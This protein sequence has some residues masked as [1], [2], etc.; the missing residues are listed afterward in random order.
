MSVDSW[1]F[2]SNSSTS[3]NGSSAIWSASA[4]LVDGS[5]T[6]A[7]PSPVSRGPRGT[8]DRVQLSISSIVSGRGR[9]SVSGS[10]SA[11][12]PVTNVTIVKTTLGIHVAVVRP[13]TR[14]VPTMLAYPLRKL[15]EHSEGCSSAAARW[16]VAVAECTRM[17][18]FCG[19]MCSKKTV[20]SWAL[21]C[22]PNFCLY[23]LY[24]SSIL[25]Y[26]YSSSTTTQR[27]LLSLHYTV[28]YTIR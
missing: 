7:L 21:V 22:I 14:H 10:S 8:S 25:L 18:T 26:Y 1:S 3:W 24:N 4:A 23:S 15:D 19:R 2:T 17:Y 20:S 11:I 16:F 6:C 9:L 27:S 13:W 28:F 5:C 12:K